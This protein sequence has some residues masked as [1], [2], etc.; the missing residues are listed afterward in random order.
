MG[1]SSRAQH[2]PFGGM[3]T[4]KEQPDSNPGPDPDSATLHQLPKLSM[5]RFLRLSM[6]EAIILLENGYFGEEV[7]VRPSP[8]P[9]APTRSRSLTTKAWLL[10]RRWT[11]LPHILPPVSKIDPKGKQITEKKYPGQ[12]PPSA[13]APALRWRTPRKPTSIPAGA[14]CGHMG[15]RTNRLEA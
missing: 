1:R 15:C 9:P 12:T 14:S 5:P 11:Q 4:Q 2:F 13:S 10:G 6:G 3:A 8:P 7:R